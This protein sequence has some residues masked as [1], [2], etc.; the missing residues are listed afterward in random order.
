MLK[1]DLLGE[2]ADRLGPEGIVQG[3]GLC[4]HCSSLI[5]SV[6]MR[7]IRQTITPTQISIKVDGHESGHDH[8]TSGMYRLAEGPDPIVPGLARAPGSGGTI[9]PAPPPTGPASVATW[10]RQ[11]M[12][13]GPATGNDQGRIKS[14]NATISQNPCRKEG[15]QRRRIHDAAR[16]RAASARA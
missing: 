9:G 4:R 12:N 2:T 1:A 5:F 11:D 10:R 6:P 15:E 3:L 14:L 13:S 7:P 16:A 8:D